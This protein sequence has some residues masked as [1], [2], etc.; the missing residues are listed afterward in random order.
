M[1]ALRAEQTKKEAEVF[2]RMTAL[3]AHLEEQKEQNAVTQKHHHEAQVQITSLQE[4]VERLS[5]EEDVDVRAE[6]SKSIEVK[7]SLEARIATMEAEAE[8]PARAATIADA[9]T[10]GRPALAR[11]L[12]LA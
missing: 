11:A 10:S 2:E 4:E 6:L 7:A 8:L 12:A 9:P 3:E 1:D 5:S